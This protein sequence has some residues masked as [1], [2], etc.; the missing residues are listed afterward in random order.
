MRDWPAELPGA[1][2]VCD[3]DFTIIYM[4]AKARATFDEKGGFSLL[5]KSLLD[6]H[7]PESAAKMKLMMES[8]KGNVYTIRKN[9]IKKLIWQSPWREEGEIAGLV[10]ISIELPETLPFYD[11]DNP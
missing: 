10:E 4:N 8:G 1:V 2:T 3:R 7:K 9:G 5:G 11:R 6:C